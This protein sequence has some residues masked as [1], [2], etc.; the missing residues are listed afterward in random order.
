MMTRNISALT[1]MLMFGL[2]APMLAQAQS[3]D[4]VTELSEARRIF[5]PVEDLDVIIERDKQGVLLPRAK[6]DVLL[7]QA[8]ANAEKNA[9]P[10]GAPVVLTAAN[11]AARIVGDQLLISVTADITQFVDDWIESKFALQRLSI[12]QAK[13]DDGPAFLGRHPDGSVSLFTGLARQTY[14]EAGT[15]DRTECIGQRSSR[16]V[17]AVAR[18]P[19]VR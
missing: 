18:R 17:F 9:V 16:G 10:A 5:V 14:V 3:N 19:A 15:V 13:V 7:M 4:P 1:L 12:E 8:K 6:F 11:Y 2:A